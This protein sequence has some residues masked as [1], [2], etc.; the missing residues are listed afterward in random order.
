M[1]KLYTFALAF[2]SLNFATAQIIDF[3]DTVYANGAC[4]IFELVGKADV[5]NISTTTKTI[6]W[7][8]KEVLLPSTWQVSVCEFGSCFPNT[9]FRGQ[10]QLK[11]NEIMELSMH[12]YPNGDIGVAETQLEYFDLAD[13]TTRYNTVFKVLAYPLGVNDVVK[14]QIIVA[15]TMANEVV[16][17][18][19]D[20][21]MQQVIIT[22]LSGKLVYSAK[23]AKGTF[24]VSLPVNEMAN[25]NYVL[26]VITAQGEQNQRFI[27]F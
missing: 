3:P 13:S 25:G 5:K 24:A 11:T 18:K 27:K 2:V 14:N 7:V 19:S 26:K 9:V 6:V 15:P 16:N 4:S 20:N 21:E 10:F 1:K 8:K 12:H 17:I 22:D 23:Q